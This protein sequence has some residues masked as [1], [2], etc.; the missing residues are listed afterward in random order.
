MGI[1]KREGFFGIDSFSR[2]NPSKNLTFESSGE[3]NVRFILENQ[4][5]CI[6]KMD[7]PTYNDIKSFLSCKETLH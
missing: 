6:V 7:T 5:K 3:T 2:S 1:A 4:E